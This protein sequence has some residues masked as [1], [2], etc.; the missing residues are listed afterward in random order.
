MSV[1]HPCVVGVVFAYESADVQPV[2]SNRCC[3]HKYWKNQRTS[4]GVLTIAPGGVKKK[5]RP[6]GP[7][8]S[9]LLK[10]LLG[11]R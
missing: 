9:A 8:V 6:R 10:T 11:L 1:S 4:M 2:N 5:C 7:L 3:I